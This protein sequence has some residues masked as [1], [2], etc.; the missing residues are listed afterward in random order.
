M[1]M[2]TK[3][4][5][6][7]TARRYAFCAA[8]CL[9]FAC[10]YEAFSHGVYSLSMLLMFLWPLLGGALPFWM[11][12][13]M[14]RRLWPGWLARGLYHSGVATLVTGGAVTG[15]LEIYGTTSPYTAC[16]GP[17]GAVLCAGGILLF[18]GQ[19]LRGTNR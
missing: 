8:G 4:L 17:V 12:S 7:R 15:A 16:Y 11:L 10:V 18:S 2:S 5:A 14:R 6:C 9:L 3:F 1:F 13:R 19:C